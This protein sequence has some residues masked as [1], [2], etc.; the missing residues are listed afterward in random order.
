[1]TPII[2]ILC[3]AALA[4]GAALAFRGSVVPAC[5]VFLVVTCCFS[6]EF[7]SFDAAGL[8]WSLDRFFLA[9]LVGVY[10]A[11]FFVRRT[12][13]KPITV[14]DGILAGF[15]GLLL[16]ST[17][18]HDW[19]TVG[20]DEVPVLMHLVNGY[21]I[22]AAIFWIARE[23]TLSRRSVRSLHVVLACFGL[24]LAI[25]AIC[26][27]AGA[28]SFVF[29]KYIA[30]P[31]AGI[32][33]GRA[34]GPMVQSARLGTFLI[35]CLAA[36]G[37]LLALVRTTR[38]AKV[39]LAV[40]VAVLYAVAIVATYTRSVWLAAGLALAAVVGL[41]LPRR[42]RVVALGGMAAAAI[43]VLAFKGSDLV[44]LEREASGAVTRESTYMRVSF[45]Y[46]SW[47]MFKDRP[48]AG[49]GFGQFPRENL[50]Y[51]SD[52]D[53]SL[54]LE[55]I[56]GY[57]HHNTFL[58]V[59][60]ELGLVGFILFVMLLLLWTRSGL[61]LWRDRTAP[62][63]MRAHALLMLA[64]LAMYLSQL[65]FHEVSYSPQENS[66]I[67]LLAGVTTGLAAMRAREAAAASA[68]TPTESAR[69]F[70]PVASAG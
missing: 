40:P 10:V 67:F 44:S 7:W 47:Q 46:V 35:A 11:Q 25:T 51:L 26:E 13:H 31:R 3:I 42:P 48:L 5:A 53:T 29:P 15:L 70:R 64:C 37:I 17:F 39:C 66:L 63:W 9:M 2:V 38:A 61:S 69:L 50:P 60:V 41:T 68:Q 58:S 33:F 4:W 30:D 34:R 43:L 32:H 52:R 12:D 54:H 23:S 16:V 59:L 55:A 28:W 18:T 8:T 62:D 24:Y 21:L 65:M 20:P 36:T 1:M 45:G 14:G 57:I 49:F 27:M 19:Q 22:P 56:R 6:T